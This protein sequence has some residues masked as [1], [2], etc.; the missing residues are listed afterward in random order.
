MFRFSR[1]SRRAALSAVLGIATLSAAGAATIHRFATT[2][3]TG[4]GGAA[5]TLQ[6]SASGG[7]LQGEVASSANTGIKYPFGMLG[8]YNAAGSTFGLG[9]IGVST[10]GYAV[11]GESLSASQPSIIAYPG[12]TGIGL[13]AIAQ[14]SSSSPAI[15]ASSQGSG[16]G[17]D[18]AVTNGNGQSTAGVLGEDLTNAGQFTDGVLGTTTNG[19]YGVEGA[20]SDTALGGVHGFATTGVGVQGDTSGDNAVVGYNAGNGTGVAGVNEAASDASPSSTSDLG[21]YA[22]STIGDG[23]YATS[24]NANGAFITSAT[25]VTQGLFTLAVYNSNS[26]P[27]DLIAASSPNCLPCFD[28]DGSGNLTINGSITDANGSYARTRNPNTD[29]LSYG[30]EETEPTMEDVGSARLVEG[31]AQVPLAQDFRQTIDSSSYLVFLTPQGDSNGLYVESKSA[32]GFVVRESHGGRST[33][34]FDYR[35]VAQQYGAHDGRLPHYAKLHREIAGIRRNPSGGLGRFSI[36]DDSNMRA[37][38]L[39]SKSLPTRKPHAS[40]QRHTR[41]RFVA[42]PVVPLMPASFSTH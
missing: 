27:A 21:V 9:V 5:T 38:M 2:Q 31:R 36:D 10:T 16:D 22:Q 34:A 12:G 40:Q 29:V 13:E 4:S 8:E 30:A 17:I 25:S 28:V 41:R 20:S 11:A 32:S 26:S 24:T 33:L 42:P 37:R 23:I 14:A 39:A 18:A 15:Y 19:G 3:A 1:L 6:T 35:I 7:A